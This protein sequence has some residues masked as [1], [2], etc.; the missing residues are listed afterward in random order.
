MP[1]MPEDPKS[2][3]PR[4]ASGRDCTQ[5]NTGNSQRVITIC[6][7]RSPGGRK[8]F[9]RLLTQ[10]HHHFSP[11]IGIHHAN[12]IDRYASLFDAQPTS[13]I[14]KRGISLRQC[15][16]KSAC[17]HAGSPGWNHKFLLQARINIIAHTA[18]STALSTS[19]RQLC[20]LVQKLNGNLLHIRL[21]F[22]PRLRRVPFLLKCFLKGIA[23][24]YY[25]VENRKLCR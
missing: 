6:A 16:G 21:A 9:R 19:L 12:R 10:S 20:I 11:I 24:A 23:Q 25:T 4:W 18:L 14:Q 3:P 8:T 15:N 17:N 1:Y 5:Y 22:T 7:I 13:Y 2:Y